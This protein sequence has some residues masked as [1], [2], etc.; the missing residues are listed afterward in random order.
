MDDFLPQIPDEYGPAHEAAIGLSQDPALHRAFGELLGEPRL[1]AKAA[2][3]P[4]AFLAG[5]DIRV[6]DGL[7]VSLTGFDK[8]G[9]DWVPFTI[10]LTNCRTYRRRD[11]QTGKLEEAEVCFG[12][13]ITPNPVPGGPWG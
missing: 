3:D 8:P 9:P 4:E 7:V 11:V 12:L 2:R 10:R 5:Y 6:P 1:A 13:E